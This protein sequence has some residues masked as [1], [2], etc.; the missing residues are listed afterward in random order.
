[1]DWDRFDIL[2]VTSGVRPVIHES[3]DLLCQQ[4]TRWLYLRVGNIGQRPWNITSWWGE[5]LAKC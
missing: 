5:A 3:F 1:M 2:I 4:P